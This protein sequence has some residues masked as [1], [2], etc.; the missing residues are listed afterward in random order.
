MSKIKTPRMVFPEILLLSF[1]SA[2]IGRLAIKQ[3]VI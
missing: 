2:V 3:N 1:L